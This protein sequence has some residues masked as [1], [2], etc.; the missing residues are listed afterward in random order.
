VPQLAPPGQP[1]GIITIEDV[2]EELIRA[3]IVDETDR[4]GALQR[5]CSKPNEGCTHEQWTRQVRSFPLPLLTT[6]L[7]SKL[8][9]SRHSAAW[10]RGHTHAG[11]SAVVGH[12]T[13]PRGL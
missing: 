2:I 13:W 7:N 6:V 3:E 4:C 9:L 5:L 12:L 8:Q 1:I 10:A 11:Q